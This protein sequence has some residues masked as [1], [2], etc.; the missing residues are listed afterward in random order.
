M[1]SQPR[2]GCGVPVDQVAPISVSVVGKAADIRRAVS[3]LAVCPPNERPM[4]SR[5]G[6][7]LANSL[8]Q[9]LDEHWS[10]LLKRSPARIEAEFSMLGKVKELDGHVFCSVRGATV[11]AGAVHAG[12]HCHVSRAE[13]P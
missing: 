7:A 8:A 10:H 6:T 11:F 9:N 12:G 2:S 13:K 5:A 4:N 3:F 1:S